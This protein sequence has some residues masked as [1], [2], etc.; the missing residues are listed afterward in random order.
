MMLGNNIKN[1]MLNG[2]ANYLES[3]T[4][5]VIDI[6]EADVMLVQLAMPSDIIKSVESG[7]ITLNVADQ[8]LVSTTGHPDT[9]KVVVDGIVEIELTVG[10][11]LLLDSPIIYTGGYFRITELSINI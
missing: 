2:M 9:A 3:A 4:S 5:V 7:V 6:Y 1:A 11:D 8:A 10:V